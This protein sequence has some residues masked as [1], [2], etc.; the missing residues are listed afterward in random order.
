MLEQ[1]F[2]SRMKACQTVTADA[3]YKQDE[4]RV[5]NKETT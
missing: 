5:S 4:G 1:L 2:I 3:F